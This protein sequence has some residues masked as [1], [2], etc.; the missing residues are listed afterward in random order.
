M[1][2][3]FFPPHPFDVQ[4]KVLKIYIDLARQVEELNNVLMDLED[5]KESIP[6]KCELFELRRDL[7]EEELEDL[8]EIL[9]ALGHDLKGLPY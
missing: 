5:V 8:K 2:T 7:K 3:N 9:K 4:E 1:E 6:H